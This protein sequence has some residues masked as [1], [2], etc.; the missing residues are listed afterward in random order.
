MSGAVAAGPLR[1]GV[2]MTAGTLL[3]LAGVGHALGWAQFD[4]GLA[5]VDAQTNAALHVGWLWGSATFF[6]L[7]VSVI[8]AAV[9]WRRGHDPRPAAAPAALALLVF[10]AAAFVAR[11]GNPHFLGFVALGLLVG[12]PLVFG[13]RGSRTSDGCL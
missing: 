7:G 2:L 6:A 13:R 3:L 8:V 5:K 1:R 9:R 4:E 10:G 11:N 12:L